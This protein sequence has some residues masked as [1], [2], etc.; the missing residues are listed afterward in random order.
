MATET[1]DPQQQDEAPDV[2]SAEELE[3]LGN[4]PSAERREP[5]PAD[6]LESHYAMPSAQEPVY[7]HPGNKPVD[8]K[9]KKDKSQDVENSWYKPRGG[10]EENR[11]NLASAED[12][13]GESSGGSLYKRQHEASHEPGGLEKLRQ[14]LFVTNRRR[15]IAGGGLIGTIIGLIFGF[16]VIQGPLQ[17]VHLSQI[18]QRSF[19]R[20]ESTVQIR[21]KGLLRWARSGN[22]EE[23]RL[24]KLGSIVYN[25]TLSQLEEQGITFEKNSRGVA[26]TMKIDTTKND[27]YKDLTSDEARRAAIIEDFKIQDPSILQPGKS[28]GEYTVEL[29]VGTL[30]GIDFAKTSLKTAIGSLNNG[31]IETGLSIRYVKRAWDLPGLFSPYDRLKSALQNKFSTSSAE[32]EKAQQLEE[33][34]VAAEENVPAEQPEVA[35][36][37]EQE[38]SVF[39]SGLQQLI[40]VQAVACALRGAANAAVVINRALIVVPATI[41]AADKIAKGSQ[42]QNGNNF[43]LS[44]LDATTSSFVN[45]QTGKT[46]WSGQA[47]QALAGSSD[48]GGPDLAVKYRSAFNSDTTANNIRDAVQFKDPVFGTDITGV[49]CSKPA[50]IAT[51]LGGILVAVL[52]LPDGDTTAAAYF[53]AIYGLAKSAI[54]FGG[55]MYIIQHFGTELLTDKAVVPTV[56]NGAVGGN[57]LA[58]GSRELAN[59]GARSMGGTAIDGSE[60]TILTAAEQQA[61]QKQ[62]VAES[63]VKRLFDVNDSRSVASRFIDN[64]NLNPKNVVATL[65]GLFT[66]FGSMM[67]RAF[68][69][70]T[71]RA[72]AASTPYNWGFPQYGIPDS[73]AESANYENPYKNADTVGQF[74]DQTCLAADGS[75]DSGKTGCVISTVKA[76]F[77]V[78]INKDTRAWQV[79]ANGDINPDTLEYP[80]DK[81]SDPSDMW[82][83]IRMFIFDS[84]LMDTVACYQNDADS[85][86]NLDEANQ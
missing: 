16:S 39:K 58:Y 26:D 13:G 10:E 57:L 84:R 34:Q 31:K 69:I 27:S 15:T 66:N 63:P 37:Q 36:A 53:A 78:D 65:G 48:P 80:G 59:V 17:L 12:N 43:D 82:T 51:A 83:R 30:K 86:S 73:I 29:K 42:V 19:S 5:V 79:V 2:A 11:D 76:C 56:L 18:L 47:L 68:G 71:P 25:R 52:S 4:L 45:P 50:I 38:K 81:C 8:E 41:Q 1:L 35:V 85:C 28:P 49:V 21:N 54:A 70:I 22:V 62:W 23:T 60:S 64:V 33:E 3:A 40:I 67:S 32:R 24:S 74:L 7:T 46:I 61:Q 14:N 72:F 75:V 20:N 9:N 77:G 6:D 55:A 44:Q